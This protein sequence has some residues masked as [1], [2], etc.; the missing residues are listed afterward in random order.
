M[1][2]RHLSPVHWLERLLMVNVRYMGR[3]ESILVDRGPF[4]FKRLFLSL[5]GRTVLVFVLMALATEIVDL[6]RWTVLVG[7]VG[8][9]ALGGAWATMGLGRPLAYRNGWLQGRQDFLAEFKQHDNYEDLL[10]AQRTRDE[11]VLG[12]IRMPQSPEGLE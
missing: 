10:M 4:G 12:L 6:P 2:W 1:N 3:L 7:I 9:G 8:L 11:W 5:L